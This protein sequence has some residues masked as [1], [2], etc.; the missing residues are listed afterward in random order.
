MGFGVCFID[1]PWVLIQNEIR[2]GNAEGARG[3]NVTGS[4]FAVMESVKLEKTFKV[5]RS[6]M[7]LDFVVVIGKLGGIGVGFSL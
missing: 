3:Q 6:K 7:M 2:F 4:A 5:I 1:M